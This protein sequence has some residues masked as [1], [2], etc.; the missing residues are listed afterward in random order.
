MCFLLQLYTMVMILMMMGHIATI[1]TNKTFLAESA[2]FPSSSSSGNYEEKIEKCIKEAVYRGDFD[3]VKNAANIP[4][5]RIINDNDDDDDIIDIYTYDPMGSAVELV[6][7]KSVYYAIERF[8]D[9]DPKKHLNGSELVSFISNVF[10]ILNIT[11]VKH[12][13]DDGTNYVR[14][15][16][17]LKGLEFSGVRDIPRGFYQMLFQKAINDMD[18]YKAKGMVLDTRKTNPLITM[19]MLFLTST[20]YMSCIDIWQIFIQYQS[21]LEFH[22]D[23]GDYMFITD[24]MV[25]CI[26]ILKSDSDAS[27]VYNS[28]VNVMNMTKP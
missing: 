22:M 27:F 19:T 23:T 2:S 7:E 21:Q 9:L 6:V 18:H 14:F 8:H 4:D 28:L 5:H 24:C 3:A 13:K 15:Y 17:F 11:F 16:F 1:I 10:D 20:Y 26:N 25:N 12:D